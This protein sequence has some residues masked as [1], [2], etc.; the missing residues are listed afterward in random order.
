M[1]QPAP[2]TRVLI[3]ALRSALSGQSMPVHVGH[4]RLQV[5]A[6]LGR[7]QAV[8]QRRQI[9]QV[10]AAAEEHL[11]SRLL[12]MRPLTVATLARLSSELAAARSWSSPTA[13][14]TT[15]IWAAALGFQDLA[16]AEWPEHVPS[17]RPSA[18]VGSLNV[19]V[20]SPP[21]AA[22]RSNAEVVWPA[23]SGRLAKKHSTSSTGAPSLGVVV[24]Y[25]GMALPVYLGLL[26]AL[27]VVLVVMLF[28]LPPI[29]V[30]V[31]PLIGFGLGTV[32]TRMAG[33][34]ALVATEAGLEFVRF[35]GLMGR[36]APEPSRVCGW[37][38]VVVEVG[39]F[40]TV[41]LDGERIQVSPFGRA[42]AQAAS[43][44]ASQT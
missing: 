19:D 16:E 20:T 21:P 35:T 13:E 6:A 1:T 10:M 8:A 36:P 34:G 11:P 3:D 4:L 26:L 5:E 28:L 12:Q 14:R 37:H 42:F 32:L 31:L 7:E 33:Q 30:V 15:R 2:E 27:T 38:Q 17:L 24:G 29:A 18:S 9:H 25:A 41:A 40:S 44:R 39:N 22:P 43:E 23:P